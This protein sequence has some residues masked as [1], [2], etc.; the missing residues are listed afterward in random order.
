MRER[1]RAG[2][3]VGGGEDKLSRYGNESVRQRKL[4]RVRR[5]ETRGES[6]ELKI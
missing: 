1:L 3:N 6:E 2:E 5:R 4:G